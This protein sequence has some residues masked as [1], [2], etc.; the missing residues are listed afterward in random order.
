MKERES[1]DGLQIHVF[2]N[3]TMKPL[4]VASCGAGRG[5]W[6]GQG[7]DDPT[8]LQCKAIQN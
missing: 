4:A 2:L 3:R 7:V 5:L 8:T 6:E 1:G